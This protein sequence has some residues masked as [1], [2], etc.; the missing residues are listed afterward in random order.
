VSAG[1]RLDLDRATAKV[2]QEMVKMP[3]WSTATDAPERGADPLTAGF[4]G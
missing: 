2:G 4:N 1:G 3:A